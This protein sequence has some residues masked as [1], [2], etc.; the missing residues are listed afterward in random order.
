MKL[1]EFIKNPK[2]IIRHFKLK[3]LYGKYGRSL[4]DEEYL[5]QMYKLRV[6]KELDLE[7][8]KTFNEK[9]QWLKLHDRNPEYTKLVDKY[10]VKKY[11]ADIIGEEYIV[12]TLGVYN[13]FDEIDFN[14]LPNQFVIKC[15][16]DSGSV[17]ICKDKSKFNVKKAKKYFNKKLSYNYYWNSREWPYKDVKPRIIIEKYIEA[18]AIGNKLKDFKFMCFSGCIKFVEVHTDRFENHTQDYYDINFEKMNIVRDVKVSDCI[19][20]KPACYD[21]MLEYTKKLAKSY[22][23][24]R[25]DWYVTNDRLYFGEITFYDSSGFEMFNPIEYN[26]IYGDLIKINI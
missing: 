22:P 16:H 20:S 23:F 17:M 26:E 25:I 9:L 14:S 2:L 15:T 11:V 19:L 24:V 5:K 18:F 4:S 21:E 12:P 6:G 1:L 3:R 8:P 13:S 7:N 10:E